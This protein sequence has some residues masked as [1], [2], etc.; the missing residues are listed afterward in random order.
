MA[1]VF[2]GVLQKAG[3]TVNANSLAAL[4]QEPVLFS[5]ALARELKDIDIDSFIEGFENFT[6]DALWFRN[7]LLPLEASPNSTS[8]STIMGQPIS[9]V[10]ALLSVGRVQER[11]AI[12][13]LERLPEF[14]ADVDDGDEAFISGRC[15][16]EMTIPRLLLNQYRWLEH[17]EEPEELA[18]KF[19]ELLHVVGKD[20]KREIVLCLPDVIDDRAAP[21]VVEALRGML[22]TETELTVPI[23]DALS[24]LSLSTED[25]DIIRE[26]VLRGLDGYEADALPIVIKFILQSITSENAQAVLSDLRG[27]LDFESLSCVAQGIEAPDAG[28]GAKN[29][30]EVADD[31]RRNIGEIATLDA[32]KSGIRF[33]QSTTNAWLKLIQRIP[34]PRDHKVLDIFVLLMIHDV[35][36]FKKSSEAIFLKKVKRGDFS[37]RLI[38]QVFQNHARAVRPYFDGLSLIAEHLMRTIAPPGAASGIGSIT[39]TQAVARVIFIESFRRFDRYCQQ[40]VIGTLVAHVG[41]GNSTEVD[42]ALIVLQNLV[43]TC[44]EKVYPFYIMIKGILDYIDNLAMEHVRVLFRLL[45]ILGISQSESTSESDELHIF[46]RKMVSKATLVETRVGIVGVV[47]MLQSYAEMR[48]STRKD[49]EADVANNSDRESTTLLRLVRDQIMGRGTANGKHVGGAGAVEP[50]VLPEHNRDKLLSLGLLFDELARLVHTDSLPLS[51]DVLDFMDTELAGSFSE[52]YLADATQPPV[53]TNDVKPVLAFGLDPVV[54]DEADDDPAIAL[55]ALPMMLAGK[56]AHA[57]V[58][59]CPLF[60]LL[61]SLEKRRNNGSLENCDALIGCGVWT[62]SDECLDV[63]EDLT[64]EGK[65]TVCHFYFQLLNWFRDIL[66][67]FTSQDDNEI[68][69]KIL[70]RLSG[71]VSIENKLAYCL[72]K[73]PTFV[74]LPAQFE[75][76]HSSSTR[77]SGKKGSTGFGSAKRKKG[78]S[79]TT[80]DDFTSQN[81]SATKKKSKKAAVKKKPADDKSIDDIAAEGDVLDLVAGNKDAE[82]DL[83]ADNEVAAAQP[84]ASDTSKRFSLDHTGLHA[85]FRELDLEVFNAMKF[86]LQLDNLDSELN[87]IPHSAPPRLE[88]LGVPELR[89][90]LRD[91]HKKVVRVLKPPKATPFGSS[92]PGDIRNAGYANVLSL[93]ADK[94]VAWMIETSP[95]LCTKLEERHLLFAQITADNEGLVVDLDMLPSIENGEESMECIE[96]LLTCFAQL[97]KWPAFL[98][99]DGTSGRYHARM[100]RT[101]MEHL[102]MRQSARDGSENIDASTLPYNALCAKTFEYFY[103]FGSSLVSVESFVALLEVLSAIY[104]LYGADDDDDHADAAAV[105]ANLEAETDAEK[106]LQAQIFSLCVDALKRPWTS[107]SA[108]PIAASMLATILQTA[109]T[110]CADQ[111]KFLGFIM[112]DGIGNLLE[113]ASS[114][115]PSEARHLVCTQLR[116]LTKATFPTY[117]R[118]AFSSMIAIVRS[119]DINAVDPDTENPAG[120]APDEALT[121]LENLMDILKM[122]KTLT[123][124]SDGTLGS[125]TIK[126][127]TFKMSKEFI[128]VFLKQAMPML[129]RHFKDF[130]ETVLEVLRLVQKTTRY[131]Q[132]LCS[133]IRDDLKDDKLAAY[134]PQLKRSL[135]SMIFTTQSM[136]AKNSCVGAF[137]LGVLK[138]KNM[139][140]KTISSQVPQDEPESDNDHSDEEDEAMSD[141]EDAAD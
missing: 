46:I 115:D 79:D 111:L 21:F 91:L 137:S 131:L 15:S 1:S 56:S 68:R 130:S 77:P 39:A 9:L 61:Q 82:F 49:G 80:D 139:A 53:M 19:L 34:G 96:H 37:A 86:S 118:S 42:G 122:W 63:F 73:H 48:A 120:R 24:N 70:Q 27:N 35:I 104:T 67:A 94:F 113:Q 98:D 14:A 84:P 71:I 127:G 83:D 22:E 136:M 114:D 66:N 59:L 100:L 47:A 125:K 128:D 78:S 5:R 36:S 133:H 76:D 45:C 135:E 55:N 126:Q 138:S 140:G 18:G 132:R 50:Y 123:E 20:L 11:V 106:L 43:S 51:E 52:I 95:L 121:R 2:A 93:G 12:S 97:L 8:S 119:G 17:I 88:T 28:S 75:I 117:H 7:C 31:P 74:P 112:E 124:C 99:T 107:N 57:I 116:T 110:H 141:V 13:L 44:P 65:D 92:G 6:Q 81:V 58:P 134:V 89:F 10:R 4:E 40:Q 16:S 29:A 32:I 33:Q 108:K 64:Y 109:H 62:V 90:L 69:L 26:T 129:D 102:T 85:C 54:M 72:A 101:L 60:N 38:Q 87:T 41:S 23:L 103:N 25:I 105:I 30:A 3:L